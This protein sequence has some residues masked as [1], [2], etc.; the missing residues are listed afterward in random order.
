MHQR[1]AERTVMLELPVPAEKPARGRKTSDG[2]G[3]NRFSRAMSN[4]APGPPRA[5]MIPTAQAAIPVSESAVVS[6]STLAPLIK[7]TWPGNCVS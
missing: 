4:A 7:G 3:G 2:R 5:V 6:S 1:I